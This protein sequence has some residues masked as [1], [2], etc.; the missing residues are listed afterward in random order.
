MDNPNVIACLRAADGNVDALNVIRGDRRCIFP[1]QMTVQERGSRESTISVPDDR[2]NDTRDDEFLSLTFDQPPKDGKAFVIGS[3]RKCCDILLP[4]YRGISGRHCCITFNENRRLILRD[5]SKNGTT[6]TYDGQGGAKRKHFTWILSHQSL[7]AVE[8][9]LVHIQR[10]KFQIG[11]PKER[12]CQAAFNTNLDRFL[13]QASADDEL[14]LSG[15]GIQSAQ[16]TEPHSGADTPQTWILIDHGFLGS[17]SFSNVRSVW[18]VS[19]G[20]T[21]ASKE[22]INRNNATWTKEISILRQVSQLGNV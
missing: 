5:Y 4:N 17:G 14:P 18:D 20:Q 11:I 19:T 13:L 16:S 21:Y 12:T 9:I 22:I 3:D 2:D 10:I 6:V 8:E 7:E 15:L 1:P